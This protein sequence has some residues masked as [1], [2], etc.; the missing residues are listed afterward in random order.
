M[1]ILRTIPGAIERIS[2]GPRKFPPLRSSCPTSDGSF[3]ELHSPITKSSHDGHEDTDDH[4]GRFGGP[5][6]ARAGTNLPSC[7]S[8]PRDPVQH[9]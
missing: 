7:P 6:V 4:E 5:W 9:F 2:P 1:R 8:I 3:N